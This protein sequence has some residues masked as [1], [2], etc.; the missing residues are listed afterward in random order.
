[1]FQTA[2]FIRGL[3]LQYLVANATLLIFILFNRLVIRRVNFTYSNFAWG[4]YGGVDV[5]WSGAALT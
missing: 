3:E 4:L 2:G 5:K 1:M